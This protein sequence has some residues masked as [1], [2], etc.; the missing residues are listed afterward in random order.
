MPTYPEDLDRPL[1]RGELSLLGVS[2]REIAGPLWSTPFRDVHVWSAVQ[3]EDGRQRA[4]TAA[5][6]LPAEAALTG[7]AAG[8][9]AGVPELDG[10][11]PNGL[12]PL[13]VI[14]G[15]Q[16]RQRVRRGAS[17]RVLRSRLDPSDVTQ[18]DG[19]SVTVPVRAAFDIARTSPLEPAVVALDVLARGRPDFLAEVLSYAAERP[20]WLGVPNVRRAV[21]LATYRSRS[22]GETRLRLL[23]RLECH[24]PEP[25]VNPTILGSD[26]QLLGI[27]DLLD[28][29]LGMVG[30]YDGS[31]HRQIDQHADDNAREEGLEGA[32]LIVVRATSL[33]LGPRRARTR[34][35]IRAAAQRAARTSGQQSWIWR[36]GP[37]PTPTP[38]W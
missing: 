22:P 31:A 33:D 35:R 24:L 4:L 3:P 7:W 37:L 14:L 34:A 11:A 18:V 32:G 27:G 9:L 21:A 19:I 13:P 6:L 12:D 30:E 1:R 25:E 17:V 29:A 8:C 5:A 16:P 15:L 2:W 26:G 10:L 28:P 36:S 38:H 20:R 23:W